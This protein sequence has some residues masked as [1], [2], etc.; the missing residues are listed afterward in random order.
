MT[1]W[2]QNLL[3]RYDWRERNAAG[4]FVNIARRGLAEGDIDNFSGWAGDDSELVGTDFGQGVLL[5][6]TKQQWHAA[7]AF[8]DFTSQNFSLE[9]WV[10][11][12]DFTHN[13][14][15]LRKHD[16]AT[17]GYEVLVDTNG[18]ITVN[19]GNGAGLDTT[20]TNNGVVTASHVHQILVTRVGAL[21]LV[22]VDGRPAG[23]A[24]VGAHAVIASSAAEPLYV[25][26]RNAATLNLD[27]YG[28]LVSGW[29]A[30]A[31]SAADANERYSLRPTKS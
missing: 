13:N 3:F 23:L 1:D 14:Y 27:G 26:A 12:I 7:D 18:A 4:H 29:E 30:R 21:A 15:L 10:Q 6:G 19:T 17:T 24:A 9:F 16:G 11:I 8:A 2:T 22:Y 20:T 28:G 5:D 25:Y 31:L